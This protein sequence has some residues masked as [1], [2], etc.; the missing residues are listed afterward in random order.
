MREVVYANMKK[1]P[2]QYGRNIGRYIDDWHWAY[3]NG[4]FAALRWVLG[5]E[6]DFL[7]T[8]RKLQCAV[9]AETQRGTT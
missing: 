4:K 5:M 8:L 9:H 1:M 6:W 3:V 2:E 7:D